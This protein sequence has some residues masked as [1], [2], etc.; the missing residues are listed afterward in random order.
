MKVKAGWSLSLLTAGLTMLIAGCGGSSDSTEED[1]GNNNTESAEGQTVTVAVTEGD[2]G[3]FNAWEARSEEFTEETGIE[4]E[5]IGIPYNNLLDRITAEGI[6]GDG[7]FDLVTYLDSMGPSIQQFL[8]PLDKY[9]EADD[10]SFDRF[11][12]ASMELSTFDGK[13][14]S[15]PARANVQTLFYR[16]DVFEDLGLEPP[17]TW[18]DLEEAGQEITQNTDLKA[19][20]PYYQGGNNGQNLYMWTSYLWSNGGNIFDDNMKPVFNSEE[21]IAATERYIDLL[22]DDLAPEGSVT[23]GEQDARTDFR[24]G[25]SA[26]WIGWWWVYAE[27]NSTESSAEEVA[28]NVGFSTVPTW[29]GQE[30]ATNVSTF[31][32]GMMKG[33]NNKEAAWEFLKWLTEPE[34]EL[35]IV[36]DSLQEE[37]PADQHSPVISQSENL[38]DDE[39]NELS[40]DFYNVAADGLEDA[41]PLP[42]IP[43]WPQ[44]SDIL[45]TAINDMATGGS[46][47]ENLDEAAEDVEALLE[48]EGYY[49]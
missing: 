19:I 33:S 21:G 25:N 7:T 44:V 1:P 23:F 41:Q 9:A 14:R 5:F 2:I 45:S 34:L 49:D 20:T 32:I 30:R 10:Y 4:V 15:I 18:A 26:M 46:V 38:R 48:E 17:K 40:D 36:K 31:P 11:P 35:D 6:S 13:I 43:E 8:E 12:E 27:F 22:R 29:E 16:E 3:Q 39:L 47:E 28:G 42:I 37:S 24:E